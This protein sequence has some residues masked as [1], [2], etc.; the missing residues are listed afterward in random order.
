MLFRSRS[1]LV[2]TTIEVGCAE[3]CDAVVFS[4]QGAVQPRGNRVLSSWLS[5]KPRS[6]QIPCSELAVETKVISSLRRE[7][8]RDERSEKG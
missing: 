1:I 2:G 7:S 3:I 5:S 8:E 4:S 6:D